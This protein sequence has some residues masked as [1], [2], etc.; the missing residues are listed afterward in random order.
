[1]II[2]VGTDIFKTSR[3]L[4]FVDLPNDSFWLKAYTPD[5]LAQAKQRPFSECYLSTRFAAKEAVYKAISHIVGEFQPDK[6]EIID[7]EDGRP[8]AKLGS[9]WLDLINQQVGLSEIAI[10]ISLSY[11]TEYAIA[12]AVV[13]TKNGG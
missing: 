4:A 6:I 5:E 13:E 8:C 10:H 12:M 3:L 1:M 2:G 7:A 11:E 9:E